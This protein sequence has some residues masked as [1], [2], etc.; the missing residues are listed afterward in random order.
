MQT[1]FWSKRGSWNFFAAWTVIFVTLGM[2]LAFSASAEFLKRT[3]SSPETVW[4][5]QSPRSCSG[6]SVSK[7][8]HLLKK[9]K[10]PILETKKVKDPKMY[11]EVCGA[12]RDPQVLFLISRAH[13]ETV[14]ALGFKL[15]P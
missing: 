10:V 3:P 12:L 5:A 6:P 15:V 11:I 9:K 13:L 8:T 7:Q 14:L 2:S 4:V 1:P